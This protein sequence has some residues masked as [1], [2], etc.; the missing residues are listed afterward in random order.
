M[1]HLDLNGLLQRMGLFVASEANSRVE[2]KLVTD[3]VAQCVI[4]TC[5]NHGALVSLTTVLLI[6]D[7]SREVIKC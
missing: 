7:L 4:L 2:K 1:S 3:G 5:H 6:L